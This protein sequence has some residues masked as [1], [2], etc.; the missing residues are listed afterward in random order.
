MNELNEKLIDLAHKN[1]V[2][3]LGILLALIGIIFVLSVIAKKL[4]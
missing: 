4:K 2:I 3:H 1:N